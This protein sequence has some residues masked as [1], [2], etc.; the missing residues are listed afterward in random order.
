[1][2]NESKIE[3]RCFILVSSLERITWI[4]A[5]VERGET[6]FLRIST[7]FF[8]ITFYLPNRDRL[9]PIILPRIASPT[10]EYVP[11]KQ[12]SVLSA[13]ASMNFTYI[14]DEE[15]MAMRTSL[16]IEWDRGCNDQR[17]KASFLYSFF[18]RPLLST[19]KGYLIRLRNLFGSLIVVRS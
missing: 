13:N 2:T 1:M 16:L 10:L 4:V 7:N 15:G 5:Q 14:E 9:R 19:R 6:C 3:S 17:Y 8:E 12:K 11:G 18:S